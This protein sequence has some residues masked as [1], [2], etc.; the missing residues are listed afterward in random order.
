MYS[1][2]RRN[3]PAW[4]K[5]LAYTVFTWDTYLKSS[6]FFCQIGLSTIHKNWKIANRIMLLFY[7]LLV[8][9]FFLLS[10]N[11]IKMHQTV[12]DTHIVI[13]TLSPSIHF[14]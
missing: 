5:I 6:I 7:N 11:I 4:N 3:I 2:I 14:R 1:N 9:I 10:L 8:T 13:Y 12:F